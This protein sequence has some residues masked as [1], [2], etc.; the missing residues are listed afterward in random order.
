MKIR[1]KPSEW[2]NKD[3]SVK[4]RKDTV[5]LLIQHTFPDPSPLWDFT[6]GWDPLIL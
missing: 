2:L 6:I 1:S 4:E 3:K 5:A